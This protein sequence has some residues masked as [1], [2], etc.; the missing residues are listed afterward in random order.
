M[1]SRYVI[2]LL[3]FESL[4]VGSGAQET[5][6]F[7]YFVGLYVPSE[8]RVVTIYSFWSEPNCGARNTR[9]LQ[10]GL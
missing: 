9:E 8:V 5:G 2:A 6:S 7:D 3:K 4:L 10:V 1:N